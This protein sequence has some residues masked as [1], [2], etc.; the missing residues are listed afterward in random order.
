MRAE[1]WPRRLV[2]ARWKLKTYLPVQERESIWAEH[3]AY[4]R[5]VVK[6]LKA[7]G[8]S[9]PRPP[10]MEGFEE[11]RTVIRSGRSMNYEN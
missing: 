2:L 8:M 3:I 4:V 1:K 10:V 6:L 9:R 5:N 7:A 11:R